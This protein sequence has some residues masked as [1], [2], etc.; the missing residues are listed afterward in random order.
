MLPFTL[1]FLCGDLLLQFF[2]FLPAIVWAVAAIALAMVLLFLKS[3]RIFY[4]S[5]LI[6]GL[7]GFGWSLW[8][9]NTLAAFTLP[10]AYEGKS[11]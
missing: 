8:Y 6:G 7:L 11:E 1:A 5:L 9:A 2:Y 10:T 3:G 4:R